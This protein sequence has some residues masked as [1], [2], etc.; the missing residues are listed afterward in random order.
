MRY[1][2]RMGIITRWI[3]STLATEESI[4]PKNKIIG[5]NRFLSLFRKQK[6]E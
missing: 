4:V 6:N 2:L 1:E 3:L 5:R